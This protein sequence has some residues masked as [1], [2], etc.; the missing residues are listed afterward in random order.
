MQIPD[1]DARNFVEGAAKLKQ[2]LPPGVYLGSGLTSLSIDW[3]IF[4]IVPNEVLRQIVE[5]ELYNMDDCRKMYERLC[6]YCSSLES[7]TIYDYRTYSDRALPVPGLQLEPDEPDLTWQNNYVPQPQGENTLSVLTPQAGRGTRDSLR[8]LSSF[9]WVA[10]RDVLSPYVCQDLARFLEGRRYLRRVDIKA[11]IYDKESAKSVLRSLSKMPYLEV[12]GFEFRDTR[13]ALK[14]GLDLL[15]YIPQTVTHLKYH[16]VGWDL[17]A[18]FTTPDDIV[19][20]TV[21]YLIVIFG[22][23]H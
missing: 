19:R 1:P 22:D 9:K 4:D 15:R 16:V 8:R 10:Y 11:V 13:Q 17:K 7:L 3:L 6:G 2:T 20:R 18:K 14:S 12:L 21:S 23:G 5:L